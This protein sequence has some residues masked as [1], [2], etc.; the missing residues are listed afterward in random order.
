MMMDK[1]TQAKKIIA[2]L[3]KEYPEAKC[4]LVFKKP[5]EL[6]V[7]TIL[8]AQ[9]TDEGVNKITPAL[10]K[11]YKTPKAFAKADP[12]ELMEFI[13][14]VGLFRNK[15]KAIIG[16][17]AMVANDY[18]DKVP[19]DMDEIRKLPGVGRKTANVILGNAFS[20]PSGIA[21]DTHVIR[22][23]QRLG[24]SKNK[25]PLK[26]ENDLIKLIPIDDWILIPHLLIWHGRNI[27]QAR[28]PKCGECVLSR[29]CPSSEV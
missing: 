11:K 8:S 24:L 15:S 16:S 22:L 12:D 28:K 2:L 29:L 13:K 7:A 18:K 14:P 19:E 17:M 26:I 5:H 20:I 4:S 21:V 25:D 10:F 1:K 23:S 27:C 6:V 9:S 3:K